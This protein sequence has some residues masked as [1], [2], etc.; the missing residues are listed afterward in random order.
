MPRMPCDCTIAMHSGLNRP[1]A[2]PNSCV[3]ATTPGG[4]VTSN[5]FRLTPSEILAIPFHAWETITNAE[6]SAFV[7][8]LHCMFLWD[9]I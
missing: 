7:A 8:R 4:A 1:N 2:I 6:R 3:A 5:L 9:S